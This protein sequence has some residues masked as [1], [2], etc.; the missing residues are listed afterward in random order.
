M[1]NF[2]NITQAVKDNKKKIKITI[3]VNEDFE[4]KPFIPATNMS[5]VSDKE[6]E[7]LNTI[8]KESKQKDNSNKKEINKPELISYT[9]GEIINLPDKINKI[10]DLNNHYSFG[11]NKVNSILYSIL[12]I[13]DNK[14]KLSDD[15]EQGRL[16][17]QLIDMLHEN[18]AKFY[19]DNKYSKKG[20]KKVNMEKCLKERFVDEC[21]F[22]Y[23][24]DFLN[25]NI[26][27]IDIVDESY[28]LVKPFNDS[29]KNV[30][31]I[32]HLFKDDTYY[33]PLLNIFGNL[34]KKETCE[35]IFD[36]YHF[37]NK[38]IKEDIKEVKEQKEIKENKESTLSEEYN[39]N[40]T[41]KLKSI[42]SY[43]LLEIQELSKH[44]K[45]ELYTQNDSG[46][47]KKKTKSQLYSE[48]KS[49]ISVE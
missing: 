9:E 47:N 27:F 17:E 28:D 24:S 42:K 38:L 37:K 8:E 5:I 1:V 15:K 33:L 41:N 40:I 16:V 34:P 19:K 30:V 20:L 35:S 11:I 36:N 7:K 46:K 12:F 18:L 26:I 39:C 23:I 21:F 2:N 45:L 13:I 3:D 44:H 10:I 43:T 49:C 14:F 48:L 31:L 29:L 32:K 6:I 25:I 4:Q 22:L